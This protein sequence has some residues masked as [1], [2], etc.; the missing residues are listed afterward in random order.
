MKI[1]HKHSNYMIKV[2]KI[3]RSC[4][5]YCL[6]TP[7]PSTV[8]LDSPGYLDKNEVRLENFSM[9]SKFLNDNEDVTKSTCCE[10]IE[11]F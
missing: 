2:L 11:V 7:F 8:N 9:Q 3:K 6:P 1:C 10:F 4:S 5:V